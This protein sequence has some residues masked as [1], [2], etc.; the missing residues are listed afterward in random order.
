MNSGKMSNTLVTMLCT[1]VLLFVLS[2]TAQTTSY[3][4]VNGSV[5]NETGALQPGVRIIFSSSA[6]PRKMVQYDIAASGTFSVSLLPSINYNLRIM[7]DGYPLQYF[8]PAMPD[9][10]ADGP[11]VAQLIFNVDN[12]LV[13]R[14][15]QTPRQIS[16]I[17]GFIKG[18]VTDSTHRPL[19]QAEVMVLMPGK[20]VVADVFTD[21]TGNFLC[22]VPSQPQFVSVSLF[23]YPMQFWSV[24][25]TTSLNPTSQGLIIVPANGTIP[26]SI[27]LRMN[28]QD[29]SGSIP[30]NNQGGT[31]SG[32]VVTTQGKPLGLIYVNINASL[33]NYSSNTQTDSAGKFV[34][35][36]LATGKYCLN[37]SNS[38]FLT[39]QDTNQCNYT[40]TEGGTLSGIMLKVEQ[41][42][43]ITG[44]FTAP[45]LQD[46]MFNNGF[47]I[48]LFPDSLVASNPFLF[49]SWTTWANV[50]Y[51]AAGTFVSSAVPVGKWRMVFRPQS[52]TQ[53]TSATQPFVQS[54]A[55]SFGA[56]GAGFLNSVSITIN[57]GDTVKGIS[58]NFD[59]GYC[60][61]GH[62]TFEAG[63]QNNWCNVSACIKEGNYF[64]PIAHFSGATSGVFSLSGLK[65]N[66]D[67]YIR[68]D[69]S[70]YPMQY[71]SSTGPST[72]PLTPY[73]FSTASFVSLDLN[74]LMKPSG[75]TENYTRLSANA[76]VNDSNQLWITC[77]V[78][79]TL[80]LDSLA[81]FS[82]D[83]FGNLVKLNTFL[84]LSQQTTCTWEEKRPWLQSFF[85]YVFV[86]RSANDTMR[87][88]I[89]GYDPLGKRKI[90]P[91]SLWI[92]VYSDRWGV[93]VDWRADTTTPITN[94]DTTVLYKKYGT[95][96]WKSMCTVWGTN[97]ELWDNSW[98][99]TTDVG[100]TVSYKV[101]MS[102]GGA[103]T[104]RSPLVQF[105]AT[106]E[107]FSRFGNSLSVGQYETYKT[108][109]QAVDAAQNYDN[110]NI[111]QGTYSEN[112]DCR[113]K[114]LSI[115]GNWNNGVVPVID[116]MGG[117]AITVP[118]PS[119]SQGFDYASINGF[120]IRNSLV[121]VKSSANIDINQCLFV[122]IVQKG[123]AG[124]ADSA[125][126]AK[127]AES[128][129]FVDYRVQQNVWQCTFIG[130]NLSGVALGAVS[131]TRI[132]TTGQ[133]LGA[134]IVP[135]VS[136]NVNNSLF[137]FYSMP[138]FP[139]T[140]QGLQSSM[141]FTNCDLW[142]TS[143]LFGSTQMTSNGGMFTANP[144]FIDS[145]NYFLPD[146]SPLRTMATNQSTIGYDQQRFWSSG[147]TQLPPLPTVVGV[148]AIVTGPHTITVTW[149]KLAAAANVD[150]YTV[151]RVLGYDSLFI[152]N[153]SSQWEPKKSND[154][155]FT[156]LD[157]FV[158]KDSV[159]VDSSAVV[160]TPYIYVVVA[161]K[162]DGS[163]SNVNLPYPPALSAY[164]VKIDA[165]SASGVSALRHREFGF[166]VIALQWNRPSVIKSTRPVYSVCRIH[167][168][169]ALSAAGNDSALV[170]GIVQ[171]LKSTTVSVDTF[172]TTDT[173]FVDR[174]AR[175][176]TAYLYVVTVADSVKPI[177]Q[178]PLAW[179]SAKIDETVYRSAMPFHA[180]ADQWNMVGPWAQGSIAFSAPSSAI[181][182][183]WDDAKEEDK[184]MSSYVTAGEMK[185]GTGYWFSSG[186]DT[187]ISLT[188][189]MFKELVAD[190][191]SMAINL[192]KGH[193]GWNQ[194]SSVFPF[195]VQP[196]WLV[197]KRFTAYEWAADSA[198]YQEAAM[199]MPW[200]AYWLNCDKDTQ[201][202]IKAS[203]VVVNP[204]G[205]VLA[206]RMQQA[207]WELKVSYLGSGGDPDNFIG[208]V[209]AASPKTLRL[210]SPKPPQA[211]GFPQV[212]FMQAN[213][214][215]SGAPAAMQ[216]LAKLYK[217]SSAVPA[218]KLEWM[219]GMSASPKAGTIRVSGLEAV[220]PKVFVYWVTSSSVADL[221]SSKDISIPA[222][223][224]QM[225]GYIVATANPKDI[226]LYTNRFEM[227]RSY[228]N[229]FGKSATME[230]TV[231]YAW[232][233]DGSKQ[234]GETRDV[235]LCI[236]NLSGQRVATVLSGPLAVGEHR[237]VWNGKSE[238]GRVIATGLYIARL[239]SGGFQKTVTM[240]K[241]R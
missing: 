134:R 69:A 132:D 63:L 78:P 100:K 184:L 79:Q 210:E 25:G 31:I 194:I 141:N 105:T 10:N 49:E 70:N 136:I 55:Y 104:R 62:I 47:E 181:I 8:D 213:N 28:P 88:N 175:M 65:D 221:R 215:Q 130:Q 117:V 222:H 200:K 146:A 22:K 123:F 30:V 56:T 191:D 185:S 18:I 21:S 127:A 150:A 225:F 231:P 102:R 143:Q 183:H 58:V 205:N 179:I 203:D 116:G 142:Q 16:S 5:L 161:T 128:D 109:Q 54:W 198:R 209:P 230:F 160:G 171:S 173:V 113:G 77:N 83:R 119:I 206:K 188:D 223:A 111:D 74:M 93:R 220:P 140:V 85:S 144:Q 41:G 227:R 42:G 204:S 37:V 38:T 196:A 139:A 199:L 26:V 9:M 84:N 66:Q 133:S 154:S 40:V 36:G 71:W 149:N 53:Q 125:A 27:A 108:I 155:L 13:V 6:D 151:Y 148:K 106:Q 43:I 174:T 7:A 87:S 145:I 19:R 129:P 208:V 235:S 135:V 163:R 90:S 17:Y 241:V 219:V 92:N 214:A 115:H 3:I 156:I 228:P 23:P 33:G 195:S 67:Y 89:T 197:N 57:G 229:P 152:V 98:N 236:Y 157:T 176:D 12:S 20:D 226:A 60:V 82:K 72:Q 177:A 2:S 201:L 39:V 120:K 121:G 187:V 73:H 15:T 193:S 110:I 162:S 44:T 32:F 112:I 233:K 94:R 137:A 95:E 50:N 101:E 131:Q 75:Y 122:N 192:V 45:A 216:K 81:L 239:V 68:M 64:I 51:A 114:I 232:N 211:F 153:T 35:S 166:S 126:M 24:N 118:Y 178:R 52:S 91:D 169:S 96:D 1:S 237:V 14:L 76:Y 86:G 172:S 186:V 11:P 46:T 189:A 158:T 238:T 182:Y 103:V 168:G 234:A 240:M 159:L 80:T 97:M 202:V 59:K 218:Q 217:S 180:A 207:A 48:A 212:Y 165:P 29:T 170:R 107:F 4:S 124:V 224:G 138:V 164:T 167:G 99:K 190:H 147:Q 34:F 61:T